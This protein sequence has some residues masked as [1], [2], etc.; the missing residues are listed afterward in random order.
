M[1]LVVEP[2][3]NAFDHGICFRVTDQFLSLENARLQE[4]EDRIKQHR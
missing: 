1:Y 4:S 2:C 3:V